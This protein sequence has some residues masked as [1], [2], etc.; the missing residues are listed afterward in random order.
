MAR[1]HPGIRIDSIPAEEG[2]GLIFALGTALIFLLAFPAL[3][4]IA[5]LAVL[6]GVI[7]AP[8]LH[9]LYR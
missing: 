6:G 7:L 1:P 9:R 5:L 4:P 3:R 8:I 2:G